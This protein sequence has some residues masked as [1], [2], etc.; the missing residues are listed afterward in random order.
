MPLRLDSKAVMVAMIENPSI[1]PAVAAALD[2]DVAKHLTAHFKHKGMG[3]DQLKATHDALGDESLAL[4]F[5]ALDDKAITALVKK[6][7]PHRTDGEPGGDLAHLKDLASGKVEPQP[8]P[9][10][11]KKATAP[12]AKAPA[13]TRA[14]ADRAAA[15]KGTGTR[16]TGS[17]GPAGRSPPEAGPPA[18]RSPGAKKTASDGR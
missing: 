7:D 17:S 2:K 18:K 11:P 9:D 3:L 6:A 1:F 8:K 4:A 10:K 5:E 14:G 15:A 13:L 16:P 12:R